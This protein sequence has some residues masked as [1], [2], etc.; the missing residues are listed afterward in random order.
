MRLTCSSEARKDHDCLNEYEI[1]QGSLINQ[2]RLHLHAELPVRLA[3]LLNVF[4]RVFQFD[5]VTLQKGINFHAGFVTQHLTQ[6]GS[7]N[8]AFAVGSQSER[9][10][11]GAG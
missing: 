5:A 9:L 2:D 6:L 3:I 8:L 10:E 7:R 11:R 1:V 4:H